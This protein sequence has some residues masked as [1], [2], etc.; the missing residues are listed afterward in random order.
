MDTQQ[1]V[2]GIADFGR[3]PAASNLSHSSASIQLIMDCFPDTDLAQ[4]NM[5]SDI[6]KEIS[7]GKNYFA[8]FW[9]VLFPFRVCSYKAQ[10]DPVLVE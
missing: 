8:K 1:G 5:T 3:R 4:P 2:D 7:A 10:V 6:S 9:L